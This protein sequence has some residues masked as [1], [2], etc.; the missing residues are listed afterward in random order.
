[1]NQNHEKLVSKISSLYEITD[2]IKFL[3][4]EIDLNFLVKTADGKKAILKLYSINRDFG[5]FEMIEEALF[6]LGQQNLSTNLPRLIKTL[7]HNARGSIEYEGQVYET[8]LLTWIEGNLWADKNP[9]FQIDC[10][11]LG[12]HAGMLDK[13]LSNFTHPFCERNFKWDVNQYDWIE[14]HLELFDGNQKWIMDHFCKFLS[15]K[16]EVL[17]QLPLSVIHNDLNDYNILLSENGISGF[18]DFGDM[19]K[20]ARINELAICLA[21]TMMNCQDP[22]Q[23]ALKIIRSYHEVLPLQEDEM[24]AL[25]Y[26][27]AAR[28]MISVTFS[29]IRKKESPDEAYLQ[30]SEKPAWELLLKWKNIHPDYVTLRFKEAI[31]IDTSDLFKT[32]AKTENFTFLLR[33]DPSDN[34]QPIDLSIDSS[35]LANHKNYD[36]DKTFVKII[37]RHL[38]DASIDIAYGGYMECR[39][40]YITPQYTYKNNDGLQYRSMH[41]GMDFWSNSG[42]EVLA[43]FDATIFSFANNSKARDYGP[44]I[45]LKHEYPGGVFFTLYGHLSKDSLE[46]LS[47][48]MFIGQ[49][50]TFAKIGGMEENGD[51]P[52][53]LHF[54]IILNMFNDKTDYIGVA[55]AIDRNFCEQICPNPSLLFPGLNKVS[56]DATVG[57]L[58]KRR[59]KVLGSNLSVSYKTPLHI[60]RGKGTYLIDHL[61][62]R[63]LDTVNNIAHVGHENPRVVEAGQK[64]MGILNTNS[65]YLH[66]NVLGYAESLLAKMPDGLDV[67]Y[68]VN[69]GSEANELALRMARVCSGSEEYIIHEMGYHGNTSTMVDISSYKF[70]RKGGRGSKHN[71]HK[72]VLPDLFRG[73]YRDPETAT[74]LYVSEIEA[75]LGRLKKEGRAPGAFITESILSCG[76]QIVLPKNYLQK[77]FDLVRADGGLC[78]VDEVQVGFG[79][80]GDAFWGFE[81]QGVVPDIVTLGKPIGNGHPIG[82]VVCSKAVAEKF[83]NGMEFFSSFGANP[84]S[85]AIA[86]EVLNV[87]V[88]DELQHKAKDTGNYLLKELRNLQSVYPLLSDVRGHGLFL[89]IECMNGTLPAT[90]K[91]KYIKERMRNFGIL[92]STDGPDENVI[93]IKPPMVFGKVQADFVLEYLNKVL[94]EDFI[95]S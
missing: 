28:L 26:C 50:T 58:Q 79:R 42:T 87:V 35:V 46:G 38:E 90:Q 86:Q 29:A 24:E 73:K 44:T 21:Y 1:M 66:E 48:G 11:T 77:S 43:P 37:E 92:M 91:A 82:V 47:E 10:E 65:R 23:R 54:Q 53:H 63:Y 27:I 83:N 67:C 30:I 17:L 76:G 39:P 68:F 88:E 14:N 13:A 5:F 6:Y 2:L 19:I 75:G 70:D 32:W 18:I 93:K 71:I 95:R 25:Y 9:I 62:R 4:G 8:H 22:M 36:D 64:Q 85:M 20:T 45:I 16:K 78:I 72:L 61:G 41:L 89:G 49:G 94:K 3:P 56:D 7:G 51:W 34:I 40:F 52:P 55:N 57:E 81:L 60:L 59:A 33:K 74:D 12:H 31:G 15:E 80:V 69:S 84:V